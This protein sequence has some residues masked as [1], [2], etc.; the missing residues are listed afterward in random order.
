[1]LSLWALD[2]VTIYM[3]S[4][5]FLL[6][7]SENVFYNF[8]QNFSVFFFVNNGRLTQY[9]I[10][11]GYF[12]IICSWSRI[13]FSSWKGTSYEIIFMRLHQLKQQWN[14]LRIDEAA[15]VRKRGF[16]FSFEWRNNLNFYSMHFFLQKFVFKISV[17]SFSVTSTH[18]LTSTSLYIDNNSK[19]SDLLL[20]LDWFCGG[21]WLGIRSCERFGPTVSEKIGTSFWIIWKYFKSE[22]VSKISGTWSDIGQQNTDWSQPSWEIRASTEAGDLF[23]L[24]FFIFAW[25]W[26]FSSTS[27]MI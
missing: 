2:D 14:S 20:L 7:A 8:R 16:L 19:A 15:M 10:F 6:F 21:A 24:D 4:R 23:L 9:L 13:L 12:M 25:Q 5:F 26:F 18:F 11:L 3:N 17:F 22:K 1:M 27:R